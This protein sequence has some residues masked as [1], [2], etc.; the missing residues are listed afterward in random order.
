MDVVAKT[1]ERQRRSEESNWTCF[2][3]G[4]INIELLA[5]LAHC[6]GCLWL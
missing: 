5:A 1:S 4:G 6:E 2:V 3:G